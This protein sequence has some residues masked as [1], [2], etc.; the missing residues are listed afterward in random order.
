MRPVIGLGKMAD[1]PFFY[2]K[3]SVRI[4]SLEELCYCIVKD[5][6]LVDQDLMS[7]K[8]INWIKDECGLSELAM[9]LE[10]VLR[11]DGAVSAFVSILLEYS[12]R[13]PTDKIREIEEIVRLNSNASPFEK[14]KAK[15]DYLLKNE[16][17]TQAIIGYNEL[18]EKIPKADIRLR[19]AVLFNLGY[20]YAH[21]FQFQNAANCYRLSYQA[22]P[23]EDS[24][25]Q[26]LCAVRIHLDENEYLKFI[27]ENEDLYGPSQKVETLI[28]RSEEMFQATECYRQLST[29]P[30]YRDEKAEGLLYYKK[31]LYQKT[32]ELKNEYRNMTGA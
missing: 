14:E 27:S 9:S 32:E 4:Y 12:G 13:Y 8:L 17:Y 28:R 24:L 1:L 15:A 16:K 29:L 20:A 5:A 30:M 7:R 22:Y 26:Y 19:A 11:T 10:G 6:Y 21:L 18:M 31:E 23:A 3:Q 25:L 2:E